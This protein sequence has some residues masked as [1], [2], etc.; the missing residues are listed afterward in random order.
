MEKKDDDKAEGEGKRDAAAVAKAL[1]AA[2]A[3][4]AKLADLKGATLTEE[5]RQAL[6]AAKAKAKA[7]L[8]KKKSDDNA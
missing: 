3:A 6:E 2:E 4:K 1:E 7:A 5:Q 8:E